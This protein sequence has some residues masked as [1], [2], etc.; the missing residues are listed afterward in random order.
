[1]R[2]QLVH[3]SGP[4]RGRTKTY[5]APNLLIGTDPDAAVR[6]PPGWRVAPRHAEIAYSPEDCAFFA[7]ALDGALF[8]N[9]RQVREVQLA[10]GDLLEFGANGPKVRFHVYV[11]RGSVCKPVRTMLADAGAVAQEAGVFAFTQSFLRDLFTHATW[12]LKVFF[13]LTL[14]LVV[15]AVGW[16]SGWLGARGPVRSL[17]EKQRAAE[18]VV[19]RVRDELARGVCLVHGVWAYCNANGGYLENE[20]GQRL[21][22]E[23][24]GS[25]FLVSRDGTIV[26]N[27]H[28]VRPWV[29]NEQV[30]PL[31]Q[32]GFTPHF[33]HFTVTFPDRAPL[34]LDPMGATLRS[35]DVDVALLHAPPEAVR[36][37]PVLPLSTIEPTEALGHHVFVLGF[38]TGLRAILARADRALVR[39]LIERPDATQAEII[40]G[41]AAA[42]EIRPLITQGTLAAVTATSLVYD[43][44]TTTG[45]SGG[46]VLGADGTVIGVTYAVL[47]GFDSSNFAVPIRFVREL[48]P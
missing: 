43:A 36:D 34:A 15:G 37:V 41:L 7:R 25:G 42:G 13:P 47:R 4:Q 32:L 35:D 48:L 24:T 1:V 31:A 11:P 26:T 46:P 45:G 23:Y 10:E 19:V 38:P 17:D 30:R 40:A 18:A 3:L 28:V 20:S 2:A 39:R 33:V 14:L 12:Q 5:S 22:L 8:V 29:D 44:G 9:R 16:L 21:E 27:R 6:F